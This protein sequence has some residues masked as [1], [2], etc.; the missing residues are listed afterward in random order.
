MRCRY[1]IFKMYDMTIEFIETLDLP[2]FTDSDGIFEMKGPYYMLP[3]TECFFSKR[4]LPPLTKP[5][6]PPFAGNCS[7]QSFEENPSA[8]ISSGFLVQADEGVSYPV[9]DLIDVIYRH[10]P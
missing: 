6:P 3:M 5:P 7:G 1:M 4:R 2:M 10:L 8:P 9:V